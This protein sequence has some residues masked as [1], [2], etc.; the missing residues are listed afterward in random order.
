MSK[1]KWSTLVEGTHWDLD[2]KGRIFRDGALVGTASG[3]KVYDCHGTLRGSVGGF[4]QTKLYD[5]A[6]E[7]MGVE[8]NGKVYM[9]KHSESSSGDWLVGSG[10]ESPELAI[11]VL[12][13]LH[14]NPPKR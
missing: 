4:F 5:A 6:G 8:R 3:S 13:N 14:P 9:T 7:E 10:D 12:E 1:R 2:D 11:A